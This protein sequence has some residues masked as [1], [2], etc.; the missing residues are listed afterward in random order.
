[1]LQKEL[2]FKVTILKKIKSSNQIANTTSMQVIEPEEKIEEE[3]EEILASSRKKP[4]KKT[5]SQL[6]HTADSYY[7]KERANVQIL[8]LKE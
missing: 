4:N 1:M 5:S 3:V 8:E 6:R 2:D 7:D